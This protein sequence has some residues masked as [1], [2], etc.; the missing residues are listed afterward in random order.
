[1]HDVKLEDTNGGDL[2][3]DVHNQTLFLLFHVVQL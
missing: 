2:F 3:A 1:V